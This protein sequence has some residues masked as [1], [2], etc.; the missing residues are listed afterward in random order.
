MLDPDF[1]YAR[2]IL[3]QGRLQCADWKDLAENKTKMGADLSAGSWT[4]NPLQSVLLF[5]SPQSLQQS[6]RMWIAAEC[7]PAAKPVTVA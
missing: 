6:A 5:E 4:P 1:K 7:A 3:V 2:G